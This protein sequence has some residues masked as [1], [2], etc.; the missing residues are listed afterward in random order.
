M[1]FTD[2]PEDKKV[3]SQ[4]VLKLKCQTKVVLADFL[5]RLVEKG[6]KLC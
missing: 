6:R 4:L 5:T 3:C 2:S 1:P